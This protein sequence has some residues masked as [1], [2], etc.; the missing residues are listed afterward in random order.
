MHSL[1][2]LSQ[3][4]PAI[5]S[6]IARNQGD[7]INVCALEGGEFEVFGAD[8]ALKRLMLA[9]GLIA[10]WV[11][12]TPESIVA[13]MRQLVSSQSRCCEETLCASRPAAVI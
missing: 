7:R 10:W 8:V 12:S 6:C 5:E 13:F 9:E 1:F 3:P 4:A 11:G 2:V